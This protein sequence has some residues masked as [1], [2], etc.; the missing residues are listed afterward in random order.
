MSRLGKI[1]DARQICRLL[2]GM[3]PW[4]CQRGPDR[5]A[6]C[7]GA[8]P[9]FVV[10]RSGVLP[11]KGSRLFDRTRPVAAIACGLRVARDASCH[12]LV[13]GGCSIHAVKPTRRRKFPFSPEL[14]ESRRERLKTARYCPGVGKGAVRD[15]EARSGH[16]GAGTASR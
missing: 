7:N 5:V 2:C 15:L 1:L 6:S 12:F 11:P 3:S 14:V 4:C 16:R 10:V 13:E 9:A 8:L